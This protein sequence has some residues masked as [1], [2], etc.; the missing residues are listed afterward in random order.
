M[1]HAKQT[2]HRLTVRTQPFL[3][4]I[5]KKHNRKFLHTRLAHGTEWTFFFILW[6]APLAGLQE[7][8]WHLGICF[9]FK[10][11]REE[12]ERRINIVSQSINA[13]FAVP[14]TI[15]SDKIADIAVM[16][17]TRYSIFMHKQSFDAAIISNH[18]FSFYFQLNKFQT[19]AW[20]A[21]PKR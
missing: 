4:D 10:N 6:W 5:Y 3:N 20:A 7:V 2:N 21:T 18:S 11:C 12:E 19:N 14:V 17:K 1:Q 16:Y 9:T 8:A 13:F 15:F